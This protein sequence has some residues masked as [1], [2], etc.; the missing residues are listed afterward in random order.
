MDFLKWK[1]KRSRS[2]HSGTP[3]SNPMNML[4]WSKQGSRTGS[5]RSTGSRIGTT[6]QE[7]LVYHREVCRRGKRRQQET[8]HSEKD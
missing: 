2:A 1:T 5:R 3:S 7:L 6:N 8:G 4:E